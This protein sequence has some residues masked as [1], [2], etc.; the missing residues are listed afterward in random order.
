MCA[1]LADAYLFKNRLVEAAAW[2]RRA[3]FLVDSL[4]LPK[5]DNVTLYMGLAT[6]YQ[7]L[8]DWKTSLRYYQQTEACMKSMSVGMQAY[9]LNNYGNYYYYAKDYEASLR[10]FVVLKSLLEKHHMQDNFDMFIC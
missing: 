9:F 10:K 8:N 3:L 5:Q 6:I 2:Y 1:N 7:Q 4:E